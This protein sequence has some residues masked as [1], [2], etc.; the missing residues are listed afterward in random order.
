MQ[1]FAP[2]MEK[3]FIIIFLTVKIYSA[4]LINLEL[5][6]ICGED[7]KIHHWESQI[8]KTCQIFLI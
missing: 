8:F 1:A 6:L 2:S 5:C 7:W 4:N 3:K